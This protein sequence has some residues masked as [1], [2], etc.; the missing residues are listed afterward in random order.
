MAS[1]P[2]GTSAATPAAGST[3]WLSD[4]IGQQQALFGAF[5]SSF[6]APAANDG[7]G[8]SPVAA[9]AQQ[10]MAPWLEAAKSFAAWQQQSLQQ[11]TSLGMGMLPG[12]GT[13][14][15]DAVLDA[16]KD[17]RFSSGK[18]RDDPRFDLAAKS[19]LAQTGALQKAL[20][21]MPLDDRVKGQWSFVLKQ[22]VDALS[23]ANWLAT[24]PEA[25]QTALDS[26][27]QSL[28]EGTKLFLQDLAKGRVSMTDETAFEVGVNVALTP[29]TVIFENEM[30]QI[31]QYAPTT[32]QVYERPLLVI[33]PCI[34]KYYILDLQ[35]S[36]S[37]VGYAVGQGTLCSWSPGA[38][39]ARDRRS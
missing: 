14:F 17:K 30:M 24:N 13:T 39:P 22:V 20:D 29:G 26:N 23:P 15:G 28:L 38:A 7:S 12:L 3:Q 6:G 5:G 31:I 19:Y 32:P 25:I 21:A 27:G 16:S 35:P 37:F 10:M 1:N 34:N 2:S 9:A 18:W 11:F 4:L 33:P 36:N 8:V